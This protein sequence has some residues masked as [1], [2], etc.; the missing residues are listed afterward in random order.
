MGIF[1]TFCGL[2]YNDFFSIPLDL[3]G[4][5]YNFDSGVK[6]E[7]DCVYPVG[8]DP[9]WYI[10][11][12]EIQYLNSI[13]MKISVI[14]GVFHM[15]LGIVQKGFNAYYRDDKLELWHEFVPQLTM[16]LCLFGY[17]DLMILIKWDTDYTGQAH[18]AP[19]I[20][21]TMVAMFLERGKVEGIPLFAG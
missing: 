7:A 1:S 9:I 4:S 5:C 16:L 15:S 20:I 14:L 11:A 6:K 8:V 21:S 3:F 10:S 19:A 18:D 2:V 17:M 13:K 12:Q